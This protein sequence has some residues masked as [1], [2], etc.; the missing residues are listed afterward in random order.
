MLT[1]SDIVR[2]ITDPVMKSKSGI[3]TCSSSGRH[4]VDHKSWRCI[5]CNEPM[6][7]MKQAE[8]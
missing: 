1:P 5:R 6:A 4:M 3:V 7:I 8:A 2:L